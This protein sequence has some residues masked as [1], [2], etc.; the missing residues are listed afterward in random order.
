MVSNIKIIEKKIN[1]ARA[2]KT[3]S[4]GRGVAIKDLFAKI[5]KYTIYVK[6]VKESKKDKRP[7]KPIV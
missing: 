6:L 4:T 3:K 1:P 2:K 7:I 5:F